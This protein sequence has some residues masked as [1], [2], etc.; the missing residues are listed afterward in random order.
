MCKHVHVEIKG[1]T[2]G[3]SGGPEDASEGSVGTGGEPSERKTGL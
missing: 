2:P 1:G 3:S